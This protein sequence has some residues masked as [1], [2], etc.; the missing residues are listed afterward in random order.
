MNDLGA[1]LR[2]EDPLIGDPGLT[3]FEVERM[4]MQLLSAASLQRRTLSGRVIALT[5]AA[6]LAIVAGIFIV[7]RNPRAPLAAEPAT[8]IPDAGSGIAVR[9]LQFLTPGGT[10]V[11]WTF[12]PDF[13]VR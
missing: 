13:D 4:R 9:Q 12:N 11:I 8:A 2:A 7:A 1:R 6:A 10:R 3:A 5:A